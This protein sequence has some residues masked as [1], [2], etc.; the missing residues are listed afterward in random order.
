MEKKNKKKVETSFSLNKASKDYREITKKASNGKDYKALQNELNHGENYIFQ[1]ARSEVKNFD[2]RFINEL[3]EGIS[4]IMKILANPRTFIREDR[5]LVPAELAKKVSTA[6]IIHFSTH[7]QYIRDVDEDG[8]V[9]PSK[10]L[11]IQSET[12]LAIYENRFIMTLIRRLL[13]F[14]QTRY[15][16]IIEH[17]ETYDSDL[18]MVHN[19]TVIGGVTY[20]VDTRVKASVPSLDAGNSKK[21]DELLLKLS[22]M[23]KNCGGFLNSPFME[24]MR[25]AKEVNSPIH[26]TNMLRKHP[27]YHRAYLLWQFLD[28][29]EDLGVSYDVT[30]TSQSFSNE[31]KEEIS[32]YVTNSILLIHS[33]RVDTEKLPVSRE[34]TYT[35]HVIFTLDDVTYAESKFVYDAYPLAK[36]VDKNPMALTPK[37]VKENEERFF[38]KL[39]EEKEIEKNVAKEILEDKDRIC[40]E[41][42]LKRR[43]QENLKR[44][45]IKQNADL[46]KE[47]ER[48]QKELQAASSGK[49]KKK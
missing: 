37:E 31:Y 34:I 9:T 16:Y 7:S 49:N 2:S 18:L 11:T 3:E 21:N 17:N 26:M 22:E 46:R 44:E 8:N 33:N 14:I 35:P 15:D 45:L 40:Y 38:A 6:S 24:Q 10:I 48:L 25:G 39:Q 29:Y 13:R 4:A 36:Q 28:A 12:D 47:V 30:E 23:R 27:D 20:E 43:E 5:E 1:A 42:A 41:E 32:K 19:K